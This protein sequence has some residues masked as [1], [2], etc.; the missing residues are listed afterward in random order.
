M[1][2]LGCLT[3]NWHLCRPAAGVRACLNQTN[4]WLLTSDGT[5]TGCFARA[6]SGQQSGIMDGDV[7]AFSCFWPQ[8]GCSR[9]FS[10]VCYTQAQDSRA[11]QPTE[12]N[13]ER[14][15]PQDLGVYCTTVAIETFS[16]WS[17][18]GKNLN[19]GVQRTKLRSCIT[20]SRLKAA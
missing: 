12:S 6:R 15:H 10:R 17:E 14:K 9:C 2:S 7:I 8:A 19:R 13:D 3:C 16:E 4:T 11:Q 18:S 1:D 5:S 20:H